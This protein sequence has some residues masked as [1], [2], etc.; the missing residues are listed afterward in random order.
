[1]TRIFHCADIHLDSPFSLVSP[2]EAERRRTELRAAFTSALMF[3]KHQ[4]T[5]LFF[6]SGDLFDCEYVTRDTKEMLVNEFMKM[7]ECRFFISPGNHD[8]YNASSPYKTIDFPKNVHIF[9]EEKTCVHIDELGVDVYGV[10]FGSSVYPASP[11][12]GYHIENPRRINILVCHGDL[13]NPLSPNGPI[14]KNEIAASGFD[15]IALG[16]AHKPSGVLCENGVYYAYPGCI[17]GR[18]FDE[19]GY[20]GA[21]HGIVEKGKVDLDLRIFSKRRYEIVKIDIDGTAGKIQALEHIRSQIRSYT[22]NTALRIILTGRV[23][24]GF[25]IA[26]NEIGR[27]MEFPYYIEIKD[28]T[29]VESVFSELEK[30][31]TLKGVFYRNM[32]EYMERMAPASEEYYTALQALKYGLCALEDRSVIDFGGGVE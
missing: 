17:E 8:P 3:A 31:S 22:D 18:G 20:K 11:L 9:G 26:P 7:P 27:G 15:Y 10:G 5:E 13:N 1:M 23:S 6:I 14:T 29:T 21:L 32:N 16:H 2:K 28:Q 30:S 19:T 4:K 24:E 25:L 12:I